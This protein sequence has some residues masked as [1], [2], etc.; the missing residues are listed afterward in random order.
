MSHT[1]K[2]ILFFAIGLSLPFQAI[3]QHQKSKSPLGDFK[4]KVLKRRK[5][6]IQTAALLCALHEN[7]ASEDRIQAAWRERLEVPIS[8]DDQFLVRSV[9]SGMCPEIKPQKFIL[10]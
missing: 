5:M 2:L 3:A 8:E 4:V 10:Y 7:D 6:H 9:M 1:L